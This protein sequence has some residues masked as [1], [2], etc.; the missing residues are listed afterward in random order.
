[1]CGSLATSLSTHSSG[2]TQVYVL[3]SITGAIFRV[4]F[5]DRATAN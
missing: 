1:M 5:W 3:V 4:S 2:V